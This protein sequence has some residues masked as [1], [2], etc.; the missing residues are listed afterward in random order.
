MS[1]LQKWIPILNVLHIYI[2]SICGWM[3]LIIDS[4]TYHLLHLVGYLFNFIIQDARTHEIEIYNYNFSANLMH[5][6]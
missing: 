3:D 2:V 5:N 1:F 4:V 6:I